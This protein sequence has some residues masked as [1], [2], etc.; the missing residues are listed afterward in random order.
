M[1]WTAALVMLAVAAAP[2]A[3]M[4]APWREAPAFVGLFAPAGTRANAYRAFVADVDLDGALRVF[5]ADP[6]LSRAPGAW[7]PQ[8][9]LPLD[10][11]GQ[12]GRYDRSRLARLYGGRRPRVARGARLVDG[13]PIETWTLISPYPDPALQRLERGTLL[14]V[15]RQH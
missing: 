7:A 13:R 6:A 1:S 15:L 8:P 2:P 5:A 4:A 12:A 9:V 10:V 3:Q 14:L 11:F